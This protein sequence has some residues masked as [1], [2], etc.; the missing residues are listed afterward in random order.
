MGSSFINFILLSTFLLYIIG[1]SA[2]GKQCSD[3]ITIRDNENDTVNARILYFEGGGQQIA[4]ISCEG[5]TSGVVELIANERSLG[6]ID[7]RFH[8]AICRLGRW[9]SLN[10]YGGITVVKDVACLVHL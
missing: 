5:E 9:Y 6:V 8:R 1:V 10:K 7:N 3:I 4:E 2:T